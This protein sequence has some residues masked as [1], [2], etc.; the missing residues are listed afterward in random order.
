MRVTRLGWAALVMTAFTLFAAGSTGN[1]LLYLL[2]AATVAAL[3]LSVVSGWANL[4]ALSARVEPPT[5][6]FRGAPF[7]TRVTVTN[8]GAFDKRLI[9]VVGPLGVAAIGDVPAG[10]EA[11][12]E[13]RLVLPHRG[14][15]RVEGLVL[16]SLFPF[17]FLALRRRV[18]AFDAL[19]L[20]PASPFRP[21]MELEQDPRAMGA[22]ARKKSRDGEFF[23]PRPY[24]PDDE[25]RLI[26]WK[27]TAKS[28]RPIVAEHASAP[29]GQATVRLEGADDAAVDRAAAACRW[30][31]DSGMETGLAGPGV[32]V[33]PARG[34]AQLDRLLQALALVG[35]GARPRSSPS[36]PP[37]REPA[38]ADTPGQRRLL[39]AGGALVYL[40][41]FLIDDLDARALLICAPL[42]PLGIYVQERGGP[43]LSG[44]LSNILSLGMLAFLALVDF[45]RSGVALANTHLLVY[46]L[47]NR[48]LSPWT[49]RD[50]RQIFLILYL[51]FFLVSGLTISPWYFPLFVA[52]IA[53]AGAWLMNQAGADPSRARAWLPSLGRQLGLGA[54]LGAAVFLAVPRVE[55]LRRF[56]PFSAS[57][58][59]K[60]QVRSQS[61]IGFT[62]KVSLGF[63]G[64]LKRSPARV[65][66]VRPMP[67]PRV[68]PGPIYVRGAALDA[69]DGRAW[70]KSPLDFSFIVDGR[71]R[72]ARA[73]RAW[74]PASEGALVFPE[75]PSP[76]APQY[77]F[78][79]YPIQISVVFTVGA[80]R[81]IEGIGQGVWFDHTDSV[82]SAA[83][84]TGGAHYKV[85]SAAAGAEPTD[86]SAELREPALARALEV[87]E[88]PGG[89]E[90][91]LARRW[92]RGLS[93]PRAKANAIVA[94]LM[95]E[96]S[97]SDYSDG[98]RTSLPDFLFT[99][100]KGT[101]EYFAT[102]AAILL[103]RVGVPTRLVTGFN[104]SEWNEWGRFYDV[105]QSQAHAWIEAWIPGSGWVSYDATPGES[106][107]SAA[108]DELSRRV[109][110]WLDAA[111]AS[112]YRSVIGYDQYAQ[113]DT[114]LRLSFARVFASL[115]E[116]AD[117]LFTRWAP[118][119]LGAGL[120]L[121]AARALP[122]RL[123]RGDEFERAERALA[124]AG[125]RRR[126]GDTPREF[127]RAVAAARPELAAVA[128]LAEGHY[129]RRYEGVTP[130]AADRARAAAL[131][132]EI[133]ARL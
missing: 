38:P 79:L 42:V 103:R 121:W 123:R 39:Y 32:E 49:A 115:Q 119:A 97:Y 105:R 54:A 104:A 27:L 9:R 94:R 112:W 4:R 66:R 72:L 36:A 98:R 67:A 13:L 113:R 106:G 68:S 44:A 55:G 61:V 78:E 130:S 22:G 110:R 118:W 93:D 73:D 5:Q 126:L 70:S 111:Q 45:R 120:L 56:N 28:G 2:F 1:N 75:P 30:Y 122:A 60:L 129:R 18:P 62:E 16:E 108:A 109:G 3:F 133:K 41:L 20:P 47:L 19:A 7:S 101:C 71:E 124:R 85:V 31:I 131:L 6:A 84:F 17:G 51:S 43:F 125:V 95:R 15:N 82:Y 87:P 37:A 29:D 86:A 33:P 96:Y 25:A 48:A 80:P 116:S 65:M 77:D 57:G 128:E 132:K 127:A 100:R 91:E 74:V 11:A 59:D 102:A 99:V 52:W 46:L 50:L 53:F 58:M 26:Q 34:L 14:L 63:F 88:D 24:G 107:F 8:G 89:R 12:A 10:G 23:G 64:T 40:A 83:A 81:V 76:G 21:Q 69:F 35:E 117:Q 90:A 114:F 92:T